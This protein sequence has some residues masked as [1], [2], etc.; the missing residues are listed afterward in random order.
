MVWC[1]NLVYIFVALGLWFVYTGSPKTR[2]MLIVSAVLSVAWVAWYQYDYRNKDQIIFGGEGGLN[3]MAW[4]A[5][6]MALLGVGLFYNSLKKM[7]FT[8]V[9]RLVITGGLWTLLLMLGEWIGYNVLNI[10][11]KSDYPGL[12]GLE[13]IHGPWYMKTY[14]LT[15]WAIYLY[16]IGAF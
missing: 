14:Y 7:N 3:V 16:L 2:D 4:S 12:F 15:A 1:K 9:M 5:W 13:L 6:T 10:K 11:L 8:F